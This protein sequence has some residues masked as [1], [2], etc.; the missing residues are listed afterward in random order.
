MALRKKNVF[1]VAI[2]GGGVMGSS[3]AYHLCQLGCRN[4]A[5][6]EKD[7]TYKASSAM[8]SVSNVGASC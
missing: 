4:I 7:P 6:I 2:I 8:L 3:I 1:D 5:V